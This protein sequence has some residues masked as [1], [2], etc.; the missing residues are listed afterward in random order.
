[1]R[2]PPVRIFWTIAQLNTW[3]E[4]LD[5]EP[6]GP[7]ARVISVF[8]CDTHGG[9][10]HERTEVITRAGLTHN[11]TVELRPSLVIRTLRSDGLIWTFYWD[12]VFR[13]AQPH[14][15]ILEDPLAQEDHA[16]ALTVADLAR[17]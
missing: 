2:R 8:R 6:A 16:E 11:W 12:P 14:G 1:M 4:S 10:T 13:R 9:R 5:I 15:T 7:G 3:T 17:K